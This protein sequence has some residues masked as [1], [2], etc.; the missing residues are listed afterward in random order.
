VVQSISWEMGKSE[1]L[2]LH[3]PVSKLAV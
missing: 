1:A 3:G 2:N